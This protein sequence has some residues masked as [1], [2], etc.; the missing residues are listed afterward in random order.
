[1]LEE[2][3]RCDPGIPLALTVVQGAWLSTA[4]STKWSFPTSLCLLQQKGVIF[5]SEA[6]ATAYYTNNERNKAY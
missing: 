1:M 6:A 5:L 2:T 3:L 4:F